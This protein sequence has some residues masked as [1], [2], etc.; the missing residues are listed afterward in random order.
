MNEEEKDPQEKELV[1]EEIKSPELDDLSQ[2][3]LTKKFNELE[4]GKEEVVEP[5]EE[6]EVKEEPKEEAKEEESQELTKEEKE[7]L[8]GKFTDEKALEEGYKNLEAAYGKQGTELGELRKSMKELTE[9]VA[10]SLERGDSPQQTADIMQEAKETNPE[11]FELINAVVEQQIKK[12]T[13]PLDDIKAEIEQ[14][15]AAEKEREAQQWHNNATQSFQALKKEDTQM[16]EIVA[17]FI[18]QTDK[19][20][21]GQ[22][23]DPVATV[24]DYAQKV[25]LDPSTDVE[26][27]HQKKI[28]SVYPDARDRL[29]NRLA[30][31]KGG[32]NTSE[33]D[34]TFPGRPSGTGAPAR[35]IVTEKDLENLSDEELIKEYKRQTK[36]LK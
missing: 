36:G 30:K 15:K 29:L 4:S 7:L 33:V 10:K 5:E 34:K 1:S 23:A 14:R 35:K 2:E 11:A 25:L 3:E 12:A 8:A 9:Q 28:L 22:Y 26:R 24:K 19:K 13:K 32:V 27:E 31:P 16:S 20:V 17:G 21:L 6:E 18:K